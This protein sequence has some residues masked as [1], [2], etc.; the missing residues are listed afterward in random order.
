MSWHYQ[1]R[2]RLIHGETWYDIVEVYENPRG[3]TQDGMAPG[4]ET[5]EGVIASLTH[6]LDD[7]KQYPV[8]EESDAMD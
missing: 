8:L 6:M 1:M 2:K 4:G 5:P 3:W 7:A